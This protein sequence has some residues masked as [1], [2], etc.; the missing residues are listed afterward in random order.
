MKKRTF[1]YIPLILFF[2]LAMTALVQHGNRTVIMLSRTVNQSSSIR[3]PFK[4]QKSKVIYVLPE[5][6]EAGM[7]VGDN[8]TAINGRFFTDGWMLFEEFGKTRV[9]DKINYTIERTTE[10]GETVKREVT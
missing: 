7:Q 10:T 5:A 1:L 4:L 8:I 9:G 6:S 3:I 2:I